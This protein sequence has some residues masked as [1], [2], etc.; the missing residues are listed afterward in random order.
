MM[1]TKGQAIVYESI[2]SYE[3]ESA[4]R[5]LAAIECYR[6][7]I[8]I[9]TANRGRKMEITPAL[10]AQIIQLRGEGK[11]QEEIA[12]DSGLSV[13][14]VWR[15]L[16]SPGK[17]GITE[18]YAPK[19]QRKPSPPKELTAGEKQAIDQLYALGANNSEIARKLGV[20]RHEVRRYLNQ[21][22]RGSNY[23]IPSD[24][25]KA[26][27]ALWEGGATEQESN[28]QKARHSPRNRSEVAGGEDMTTH[29]I[30]GDSSP[31]DTEKVVAQAG[32]SYI[33]GDVEDVQ[34][35][36][37][38]TNGLKRLPTMQRQQ[39]AR[40]FLESWCENCVK[41]D[42]CPILFDFLCDEPVKEWKVLGC[43]PFC[44]EYAPKGDSATDE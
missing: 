9:P 34:V 15:V 5:Y 29:H 22:G 16:R 19:S 23:P 41:E 25:K 10:A 37:Y 39:V 26:V 1:L 11:T 20:A 24:I 3:P 2:R 28:L 7:G 36:G 21:S 31:T 18:Q 8:P 38:L 27:F 13:S 35:Q 6:L 33:W 30:C 44:E 32:A 12:D 40:R 14:S 43:F 4:K 42:E 17:F